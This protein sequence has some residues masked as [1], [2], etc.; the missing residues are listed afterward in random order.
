MWAKIYEAIGTISNCPG[1]LSHAQRRA[2]PDDRYSEVSWA[3]LLKR[4]NGLCLWTSYVNPRRRVSE[5]QV[6][7][8]SE[9][10]LAALFN[11]RGSVGQPTSS[12]KWSRSVR[13]SI[14]RTAIS[15]PTVLGA[16][17]E[18]NMPNYVCRVLWLR[19]A[20][21]LA[22]AGKTMQ[23]FGVICRASVGF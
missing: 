3:E 6:Q 14:S 11:A 18:T 2:P 22:C 23:T 21:R 5:K 17:Q 19:G 1:F 16:L 4:E 7:W 15:S 8:R 13:Y 9:L 12:A 10:G 20:Q